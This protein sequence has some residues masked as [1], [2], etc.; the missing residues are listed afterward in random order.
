MAVPEDREAETL[1]RESEPVRLKASQS[2]EPGEQVSQQPPATDSAP[3]ETA[4]ETTTAKRS[5]PSMK[6]WPIL[7]LAIAAAVCI[8]WNAP[9]NAT[10]TNGVT[11]AMVPGPA[12]GGRI[13]STM[14]FMSALAN[15]N[16]MDVTLASPRLAGPLARLDQDAL[17]SGLLGSI[18]EGIDDLNGARKQPVTRD[19][20]NRLINKVSKGPKELKRAFKTAETSLK[21]MGPDIIPDL[22]YYAKQNIPESADPTDEILI[23]WKKEICLRVLASFGEKGT[24]S[25]IRVLQVYMSEPSYQTSLTMPRRDVFDEAV[26]SLLDNH[27]AFAR[28][29]D[30]ALSR[31]PEERAKALQTMDLLLQRSDARKV[32]LPHALEPILSSELANAIEQ[33]DKNPTPYTPYLSSSLGDHHVIR[34]MGCVEGLSE[35]SI[36]L[37]VHIIHAS[38]GAFRGPQYHETGQSLALLL[39]RTEGT[40]QQLPG[41]TRS[42]VIE[43]IKLCESQYTSST[44]FQNQAEDGASVAELVDRVLRPHSL[45]TNTSYV[46]PKMLTAVAFNDGYAVRELLG[47]V[48]PAD[49]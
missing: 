5:L 35:S 20:V 12:P 2:P 47:P 42:Q 34:A 25:L 17:S 33:A 14:R 3:A 39:K 11:G 49:Q 40:A 1:I 8:P 4:S 44:S 9:H 28:L 26:L 10:G 31:S 15:H 46:R 45:I 48:K 13:N 30:L 18:Q 43:A 37:L 21:E 36:K 27:H 29:S 19:D 41:A 38:T 23:A 32:R 6:L 22:E 7:G 16:G 24:N